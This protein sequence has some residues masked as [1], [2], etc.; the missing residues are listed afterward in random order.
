MDNV[1][2]REKAQQ[3]A[4]S[5]PEQAYAIA[6]AIED[7]WYRCQALAFAG[8]YAGGDL[9]VRALNDAIAASA[10][11][12]DGY[13]RLTVRA[14]PIRAAIERGQ[15]GLASRWLRDALPEI[16]TVDPLPSRAETL[17][18]LWAAVFPG[19]DRLRAAV[20]TAVLGHCPPDRSWR[21]ERLYRYMVATLAEAAPG[22]ARALLNAMPEGRA[23][24]RIERRHAAGEK[25]VAQ[26]FFW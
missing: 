16:P 15:S 2:A 17:W 23:K 12:G 7:P 21:A 20:R 4:R 5:D 8:R 24:T 11:G 3:L 14:W 13:R 19:G 18:W 22:D 25:G 9:A 26:P 1:Q 10:K 6:R